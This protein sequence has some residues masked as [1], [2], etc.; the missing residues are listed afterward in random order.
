MT[1]STNQHS[2]DTTD[3]RSDQHRFIQNNNTDMIKQIKPMRMETAQAWAK[4][5]SQ[6]D[7]PELVEHFKAEIER[8]AP[9]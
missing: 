1:P 8:L 6:L 5:A 3:Y 7:K 4:A 9:D 2:T